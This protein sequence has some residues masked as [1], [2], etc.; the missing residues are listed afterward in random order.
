ME[1]WSIALTPILVAVP[2]SQRLDSGS[3]HSRGIKENANT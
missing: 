2:L 3:P 1:I